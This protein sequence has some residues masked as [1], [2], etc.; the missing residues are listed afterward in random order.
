MSKKRTKLY[1]YTKGHEVTAYDKNG[2]MLLRSDVGNTVIYAKEVKHCN[3]IKQLAN[4]IGR[5]PFKQVKFWDVR[6]DRRHVM[7]VY[8]PYFEE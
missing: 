2:N 4:G 5:P 6:A 7:K 1:K 3:Y 8:N